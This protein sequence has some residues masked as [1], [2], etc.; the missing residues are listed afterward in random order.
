MNIIYY[1]NQLLIFPFRKV[2]YKISV[3]STQM[4]NKISDKRIL[5]KKLTEEAS[6]S[7]YFDHEF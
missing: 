1:G 7:K 2:L 3:L 4:S 5:F 6:L